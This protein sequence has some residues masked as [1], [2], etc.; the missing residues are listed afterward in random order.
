MKE[1]DGK[2][3]QNKTNKQTV[4]AIG[5]SNDMLKEDFRQVGIS[6]SSSFILYRVHNPFILLLT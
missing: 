3:K 6:S 5:F 1:A 2:T 4:V